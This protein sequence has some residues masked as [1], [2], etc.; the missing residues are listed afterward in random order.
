M[1]KNLLELEG[2]IKRTENGSHSLIFH[3]YEL[4]VFIDFKIEMEE[5]LNIRNEILVSEE[6][7]Q[8]N[9]DTKLHEIDKFKLDINQLTLDF[10]SLERD[11]TDLEVIIGDSESNLLELSKEQQTLK[12]QLMKLQILHG[13]LK[14]IQFVIFSH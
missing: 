4:N 5:Q 1:E 3:L 12:D 14:Y 9:I 6:L 13:F 11:S 8:G 10:Q 7:I 2:N